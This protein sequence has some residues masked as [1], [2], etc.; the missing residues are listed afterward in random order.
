MVWMR[1]QEEMTFLSPQTKLVVVMGDLFDKMVVPP[2]VELRAAQITIA[3]ARKN[4]GVKYVILRGNHD[5]SRDAD[6]KS[7]FDV[8]AE[9]VA[10]VPNVIVIRDDDVTTEN[11]LFLGWHPFKS[12]ESKAEIWAKVAGKQFDAV[13]GHWDIESYGGDT[14]NLLPYS[15]LSKITKRVFTGHVHKPCTFEM[16]GMTI[17]VT[18][19]MLPYA[20]GEEAS[21]DTYVTLP[22]SE[23][24]HHLEEDPDILKHK[25]VRVLLK[26]GEKLP[27]IDCLQLS[28]KRV[29]DAGNESLEEVVVEAFDMKKLFH[30]C[31]TEKEVSVA[32]QNEIWDSYEST[33][34]GTH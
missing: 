34:T 27:D 16:F 11:F 30:D 20:H 19:S 2:D 1:F 33:R 23:V 14:H 3:A 7:S 17:T 8:F 4:E 12:A 6:R 9:L 5:A 18:G 31:M 24:L 26:P 13:F 28:A 15:A 29:D 10:E 25:C 21:P 32:I 22:L